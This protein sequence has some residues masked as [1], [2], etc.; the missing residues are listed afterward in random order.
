MILERT[1]NSTIIDPRTPSNGPGRA[2][3]QDV[4]GNALGASSAHVRLLQGGLFAPWRAE[5]PRCSGHSTHDKPEDGHEGA[6]ARRGHASHCITCGA[7]SGGM[8][9]ARRDRR[10]CG[11]AAHHRLWTAQ[12]SFHPLVAWSQTPCYRCTVPCLLRAATPPARTRTLAPGR[13]H[14]TRC[15]GLVR[16]NA[17]CHQCSLQYLPA[18]QGLLL[19]GALLLR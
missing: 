2:A 9:G 11:G 16:L 5:S 4:A 15:T 19:S 17:A 12:L 3:T 10:A 13:R 14:D 6:H 18:S 7:G 1:I 8:A